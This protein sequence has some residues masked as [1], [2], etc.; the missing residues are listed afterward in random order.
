MQIETFRIDTGATLD[1]VFEQEKKRPRRRITYNVLRPD[2]FV[3][4]GMQG[5]KKMYMRAFAKDGEVR[6]I[7]I[8]Y[9][10]AMEGTMDPIVVAMSS[11][12]VPFGSYA[13]ASAADVP[14]RKVEYGTGLVVSA[15]GH[16]VTAQQ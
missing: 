10:Q 6:G 5:L 13:V 16:I 4:S 15:S 12:F 11:A 8:L 3:V 9:D 2:T 7:T 14:R 1:A